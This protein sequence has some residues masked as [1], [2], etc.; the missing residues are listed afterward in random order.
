MIIVAL[1]IIII[2]ILIIIF[3][4]WG[5]RRTNCQNNNNNEGN[6]HMALKIANTRAPNLLKKNILLPN[7][8]QPYKGN[9]DNDI[10]DINNSLSVNDVFID[11]GH[12]ELKQNGSVN[13]VFNKSD[14]LAPISHIIN[15]DNMEILDFDERNANQRLSRNDP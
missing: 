11:N 14:K 4:Y 13:S 6:L 10:S 9:I 15:Q 2:I 8:E 1:I 7:M 3:A 5:I 12:P